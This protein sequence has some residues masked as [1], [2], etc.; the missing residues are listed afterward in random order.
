MHLQPIPY[1]CNVPDDWRQANLAPIYKKGEK[2]DPANYR[3]VSLTCICC[4]TLE[5]ILVSKIMQHFSEHDILIESQNSFH[6]GR[7]C[8]NQFVQFIHDLRENLDCAHNTDHKQT[9]LIIMEF[10]KAFDKVPHRRLAYKLEYY[11]IRNDILQK[12]TT[13]LSGRTQKVV[14]DGV[15]SCP[16]VVWCPPGFRIRSHSLFD[17]LNDFQTT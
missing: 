4:K 5:H 3:P 14:I 8:E 10:V 2:Y 17:I 11:G 15:N 12:I 16:C 13:W 1:P 9:D 6:S 7:S